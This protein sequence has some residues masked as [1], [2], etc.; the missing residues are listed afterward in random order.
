MSSVLIPAIQRALD[1]A[2]WACLRFNFRG[3]G[4]SQGTY[5]GGVGESLD[6]AAAL[7]RIAIEAEGLPLAVAGWSFGS[8]VGLAAAVADSRVRAY[9]AVAPPVSLNVDVGPPAPSENQ[10]RA[11]SGRV[12]AV[13]GTLDGF[14][15]PDDVRAWACRISPSARVE[16]FEGADHFFTNSRHE[17]ATAVAAHIAG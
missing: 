16:V 6:A 15:G 11:F 2:G 12:Y 9:A 7:D 1:A 13:C 3:V 5:D 10:L 8:L 14:A 17:L 4:D